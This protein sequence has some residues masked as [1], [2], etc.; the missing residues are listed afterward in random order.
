MRALYNFVWLCFMFHVLPFFFFSF[1]LLFLYWHVHWHLYSMCV[2]HITVWTVVQTV[3]T[4][5]FH[6]YGNRQI[7]TPPTKSIPLNWSTK[8]SAQLITSTRGSPIPNMVQIHTLRA[9]GKW[10]KYNQNI[11]LFKPFFLAFAYRSDPWMDFYARQLKRREITQG[12]AFLGSERC[13]P[14]FFRIKFP[15]TEILRA[16]IWLSSLNDKIFKSL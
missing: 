13:P 12:C 4:A 8:K 3:L 10:V 11:F 6:S 2:C 14:N 7:S 15:K 9:S 16:W 5:T 1:L